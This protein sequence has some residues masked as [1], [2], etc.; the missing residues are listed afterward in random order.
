L[1]RQIAQQQDFAYRLVGFAGHEVPAG[2]PQGYPRVI[3]E[4]GDVAALVAEYGVSRVVVAMADRRGSLPVDE[5]MHV[6]LSGVKVEE[7]AT[8]YERL[9]GKLMLEN[10]TPSA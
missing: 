8:T 1:A 2:L 4:P 5:L 7:A 9:T 10:L 3:G 6:K